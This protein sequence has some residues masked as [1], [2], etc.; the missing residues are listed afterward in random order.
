MRR[1]LPVTLLICATAL[2]APDRLAA[3]PCSGCHEKGD[4]GAG[5]RS[6]HPPFDEDDCTSCHADHGDEGR[7][8]LVE[9]GNAL[10]EGCHDSADSGFLRSHNDVRGPKAPCLS[11]HD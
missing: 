10:C 5:S 1:L 9:E 3:E 6:V 7:L 8:L 4:I 11:C 2:L